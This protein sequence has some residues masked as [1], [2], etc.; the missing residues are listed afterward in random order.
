MPE[1]A[2]QATPSG[3]RHEQGFALVIVIWGLAIVSLLVVSVMTPRRQH[4][5]VVRNLIDN[6]QAEFLADAGIAILRLR[7]SVRRTPIIRSSVC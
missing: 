3:D 2:E 6:R 5:V 7:L 4:T 1:H